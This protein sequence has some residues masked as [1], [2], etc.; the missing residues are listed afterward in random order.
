MSPPAKK[1]AR[2][3]KHKLRAELVSLGEFCPIDE[4][5]PEECLVYKIRKLN[6]PQRLQWLNALSQEEL[7][8][9]NAYQ[10][11]CL[12]A[13]LALNSFATDY[14]TLTD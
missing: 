7:A 9:L 6:Q 11:V 10:K 8:Y 1:R 3:Q 2:V 13:Q 12:N 14:K 4:C 5:N